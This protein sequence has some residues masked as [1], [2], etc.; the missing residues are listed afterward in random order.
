MRGDFE[1]LIASPGI[2]N[3]N[4]NTWVFFDN[5]QS[6]FGI[7]DPLPDVFYPNGT[8][9]AVKSE[10]AQYF[11]WVHIMNQM[12]L[13][14]ELGEVDSDQPGILTD[15]METALKDCIAHGGLEELVLV[16]SDHGG[17]LYGYGG[18][19]DDG[20]R[21]LAQTNPSIAQAITDALQRVPGTPPRLNV[22]GF[23]ACQMQSLG[24]MDN[25]MGVTDYY[26]AS[27]ANE[28]GHGTCGRGEAWSAALSAAVDASTTESLSLSLFPSLPRG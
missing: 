18:D 9:V 11:K 12:V 4:L 10:G 23:D 5:R 21:R 2:R 17:G 19:N 28:P 13:M 3:A 25:Y 6:S 26:L 16:L 8:A 22:L 1:E 24:A 27:M 15:F 7:T 20:T 14:D